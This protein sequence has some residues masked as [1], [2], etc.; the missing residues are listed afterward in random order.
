MIGDDNYKYDFE[1]SNDHYWQSNDFWGE[2]NKTKTEKAEKYNPSVEEKQKL[3][4]LIQKEKTEEKKKIVKPHINIGV[5]GHEGHGKT[6]VVKALLHSTD[7]NNKLAKW[8]VKDINHTPTVDA[9]SYEFETAKLAV[10][11]FDLPGSVRYTKNTFVGLSQLDAVILVIDASNGP[12]PQ[13]REHIILARCAEVKNIIVYLNKTDLIKDDDLRD[14]VEME[15]RDMLTQYE[16]NGDNV[17]I[18]SGSAKRFLM[19][20]ESTTIKALLGEINKLEVPK[21]DD[22]SSFLMSITKVISKSGG[23]VVTG[24]VKKGTLKQGEEVFVDGKT[25]IKCNS[26]Q[27]FRRPI[28]EAKAGENIAIL[29]EGLKPTD[30]TRGQVISKDNKVKLYSEFEAEVY[31]LSKDEGGR[32]TPF[33]SDYVPQFYFG[34]FDS[35]GKVEITA[36]KGKKSPFLAE[37]GENVSM[38]IKMLR[39]FI[40]SK[41]MRVTIRDGQKTIG[42]GKVTKV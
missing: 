11:C 18:I 33:R 28:T 16:F 15:T 7:P 35:P 22:D 8:R 5:I 9:D 31:V 13:T 14:L 41:D 32:R 39:P 3:L 24:T 26:I 4:N 19:G 38:K 37:P 34:A 12:M 42:A 1:D 23:V 6:T 40:L 21:R 20:F 25:S 27:T 17:K 30:I 2:Y 10:T 36:I 29:C